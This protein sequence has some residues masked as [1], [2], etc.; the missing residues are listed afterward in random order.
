[1]APKSGASDMSEC[2]VC[3]SPVNV[4]KQAWRHMSMDGFYCSRKC[5]VAE[6]KSRA[7]EWLAF[8]LDGIFKEKYEH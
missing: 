3:K 1:M 4:E 8:E 2:R 6:C 7:K 5:A